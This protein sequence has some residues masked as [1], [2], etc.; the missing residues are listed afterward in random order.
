[1]D[2]TL[3]CEEGKAYLFTLCLYLPVL[4]SMLTLSTENLSF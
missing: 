2:Q 4:F 3:I 1:M